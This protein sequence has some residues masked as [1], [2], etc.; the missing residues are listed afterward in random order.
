MDAGSVWRRALHL[1][2]HL[3]SSFNAARSKSHPGTPPHVPATIRAKQSR[4]IRLSAR[5]GWPESCRGNVVSGDGHAIGPGT[6]GIIGAGCERRQPVDKQARGAC[7]VSR[8]PSPPRFP[9]DWRKVAGS[10][11]RVELGRGNGTLSVVNVNVAGSGCPRRRMKNSSRAW[12]WW[13]RGPW[14]NF[15]KLPMYRVIQSSCRWL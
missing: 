3:E 14:H 9:R 2:F 12:L 15:A 1:H 5:S 10:F 4:L 8:S 6:H 11:R 13:Q 7:V